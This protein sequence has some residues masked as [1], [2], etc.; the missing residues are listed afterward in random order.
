MRDKNPKHEQIR[1][2]SAAAAIDQLGGCTK[3][4]YQL[5][6]MTGRD[7]SRHRVRAWLKYGIAPPW[8]PL[9]HELTRI[10]LTDLDPEIY[11]KYLFN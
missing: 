9:I 7:I 2:E 3:T 1:R 8:H 10:P 6:S 5:S 4:A 11:P